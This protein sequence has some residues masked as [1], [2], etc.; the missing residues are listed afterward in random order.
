MNNVYLTRFV[1]G[2]TTTNCDKDLHGPQSSKY[3]ADGGV[4]YLHQIAVQAGGGAVLPMVQMPQG[5]NALEDVAIETQVSIESVSLNQCIPAD[6]CNP[7][8]VVDYCVSAT[9]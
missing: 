8:Q 3:C 6:S 1:I 2:N 7:W 9:L 5:Y 4:Y